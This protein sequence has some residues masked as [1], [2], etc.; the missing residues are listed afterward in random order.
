MNISEKDEYAHT[1]ST[2]PLWRES[3]YFN[4][5]DGK[6]DVGGFTTIAVMP[7]KGSFEAGMVIVK[8]GKLVYAHPLEGTLEGKWD[9][10]CFGKL[11]YTPIKPLKSW[12]I[13]FEDE[14]VK[15]DLTF[16]G[17]N[18]VFDYGD[19]LG[20]LT[21]VVGT[22]HYEHSG[23]V[24]GTLSLGNESIYFSG[25]GERDHSWGI[26]DWHGCRRWTW[27]T[28]QFGQDL[29]FNCWYAVVEDKEVLRGSVYDGEKNFPVKDIGIQTVFEEDGKTQK[30]MSFELTD[31]IGRTFK[32]DAKALIVIPVLRVSPGRTSLLNEAFSEFRCDTK[33]GFGVTEYLWTERCL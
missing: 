32:I 11:S 16:K 25:F 28:A 2:H 1:P 10:L 9:G 24:E 20:F 5:Y 21:R 3:H 8:D 29:A 22:R 7:N 23:S 33:R 31:S 17:I 14:D 13:E 18:P 15:I 30:S 19:D 4:F 27:F 6:Q 26:R 12:K